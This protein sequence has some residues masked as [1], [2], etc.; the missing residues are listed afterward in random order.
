M[1]R[2]NTL[3]RYRR[4]YAKLVRLY[5]K[6][7]RERFG[8]G[9][10]QTFNDLLRERAE[11]NQGLFFYALWLF[12]E[13]GCKILLEKLTLCFESNALRRLR[14]WA[15]VVALI[16]L[17]PWIAMKFTPEV[18]WDLFDFLVMGSLLMGVSV[19]YEVVARRSQRTLYRIAFGIGLTAA[20]L[21]V[22]INGAV[23]IIG[24]EGNPAN[25]M[26]GTVLA[27]GLVGS[28]IA[29]FKP[30][31]MAYTLFTAAMVQLLVPVVAL[32]I[33]PQITWGAAGILGVFTF[34]TVFASLFL[35]SGILFR[36]AR[37]S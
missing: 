8:E 35:V 18:N 1:K 19:A 7:F 24:N 16:L 11:E 5:S 29:R 14:V 34:N 30:Q 20:F 12:I 25:L 27:V 37:I 22:C 28:L 15:I 3:K 36:R 17:V 6:P 32:L 13:T 21:L 23:G 10:E 4:W 9:M 2:E 26:Y 31:G 33:W